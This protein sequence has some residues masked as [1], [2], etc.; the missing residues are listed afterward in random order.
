MSDNGYDDHLRTDKLYV[1][2]SLQAFGHPDRRVRIAKKAF[3][4]DDDFAFGTVKKETVIRHTEGAR[5]YVK[6]TFFEDNRGVR[7]LNIQGYSAATDKPHN[8]SFAF[9]GE[10]IGTLVEFINTIRAMPLQDEASVNAFDSTLRKRI[11]SREQAAALLN[12]NEKVVAE[13]LLDRSEQVLAEVL[14][15]KVTKEDIVA[16]GYRKRQLDIFRRFLDEPAYFREWSEK[17]ELAPEALWQRFFEKNTWMFGYGLGYLFLSALDGGKLEQVVQ[18]YD[19]VSYG[20]RADGVMKTR[21]AISSLCFIEIKTHE[22]PLLATKSYRAGCWAP[23]G[24]LAGAVAQV[25]GTVHSAVASIGARFEGADREGNPTG[26]E[27]FNFQPKSYLVIGSL[28]QFLNEHGVNQEHMKS[29][30]LYRRSTSSPE[31]I[32][33]DELYERARFVANHSG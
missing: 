11:L 26:E 27:I 19:M 28:K 9:V 3:H 7:V 24:D 5:K 29:F 6:A 8:A 15:T 25:Q 1:S 14:L 12:Q 10:E 13:A 4:A 2:R 31:I 32:T 16:V 23:S 20:K 18:G 17:L 21:G 33:F 22:T 30:E